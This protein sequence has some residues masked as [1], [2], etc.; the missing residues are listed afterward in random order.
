MRGRVPRPSLA[1]SAELDLRGIR[2]EEALERVDAFLDRA[3]LEGVSQVRIIHGKGTGAL[4]QALREHLS[5]HSMVAFH[6]P[7]EDAIGGDGATLVTLA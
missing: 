5:R 3:L 1:P 2:V 6:E 4:R 7:E